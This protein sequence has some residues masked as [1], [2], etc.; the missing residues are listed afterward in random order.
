LIGPVLPAVLWFLLT[1]VAVI[2]VVVVP[3]ML[4]QS[5]VTKQIGQIIHNVQLLS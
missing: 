4:H 5:H 1:L 2:S 3:A